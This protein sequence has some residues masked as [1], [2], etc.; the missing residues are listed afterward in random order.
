MIKIIKALGLLN[1]YYEQ[2]IFYYYKKQDF[3][4]NEEIN[5]ATNAKIT[6]ENSKNVI[7][8]LNPTNTKNNH[9]SDN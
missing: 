5:T 4:V 7:N 3:K 2:N 6:P 8:Y 9:F 1:W